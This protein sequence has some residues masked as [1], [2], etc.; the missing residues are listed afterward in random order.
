MTFHRK[1]PSA[2]RLQYSPLDVS[3][4]PLISQKH[5][6]GSL[7]FPS[8]ERNRE[9]KS[10]YEHSAFSLLGGGR[11]T[12]WSPSRPP[13]PKNKIPPS[14]CPINSGRSQEAFLRSSHPGAAGRITSERQAIP[15]NCILMNVSNFQLFFEMEEPSS[16]TVHVGWLLFLAGTHRSHFPPH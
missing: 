11:K 2:Q 8:H 12:V 16:L 1:N 13:A 14:S 7:P 9:E 4:L 3:T 10:C 6:D 15:G 5:A